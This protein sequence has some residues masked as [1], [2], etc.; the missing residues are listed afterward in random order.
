MRVFANR[1][2][3][4]LIAITFLW[5]SVLFPSIAKDQGGTGRE[6][7][8]NPTTNK[9]KP[10]LRESAPPN[11]DR[12]AV[13]PAVFNV[14]KHLE[15]ILNYLVATRGINRGR[16]TAID[17][18]YR[19]EPAI[20]LWIVPEGATPPQ[21]SPTLESQHH[22]PSGLNAES[23]VSIV[24]PTN[25]LYAHGLWSV[26]SQCLSIKVTCPGETEVGSMLST[27]FHKYVWG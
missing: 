18:G 17:G 23:V 2:R 13:K 5:L 15:F 4:R 19:E 24:R 11:K 25:L 21:A 9:K 27:S 12:S 14:R 8:A 1:T 16:L 7:P 10:R 6:Q 3:M 26:S 20:E 22:V